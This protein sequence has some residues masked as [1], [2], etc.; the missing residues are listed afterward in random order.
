MKRVR[1]LLLYLLTGILLSGCDEE[2]Q[3][4]YGRIS[5][6]DAYLEKI[7]DV[8]QETRS[9]NQQ[10]AAAV[11]TDSVQ[12]DVIV[13]LI[14]SRFRP[15]LVALYQRTEKIEHGEKLAPVHQ[16]LLTFLRLQIEA[17]DLVIQGA[18]QERPELFDQF[19]QRQADAD[20]AGRILDKAIEELRQS[21]RSVR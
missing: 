18:R 19:G 17:F 10:V 8:L 13:P 20:A 5:E 9:L 7:K 21:R 2:P 1:L 11:P 15:I 16:K 3:T 6:I 12:A 4:E 14:E